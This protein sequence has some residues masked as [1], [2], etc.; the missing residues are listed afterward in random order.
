VLPDSYTFVG[1]VHDYGL[2]N[3]MPINYTATALNGR[4]IYGPM[5]FGLDLDENNST[6]ELPDDVVEFVRRLIV[7][8]ES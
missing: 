8:P 4:H 2:V 5:Y 7:F 1:A 3:G 6:V